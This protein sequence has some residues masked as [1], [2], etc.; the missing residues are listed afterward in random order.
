MEKTKKERGVKTPAFSRRH[1]LRSIQPLSLRKISF[2]CKESLDVFFC[3]H[4][5]TRDNFLPNEC[6]ELSRELTKFPDGINLDG[7]IDSRLFKKC[8]HSRVFDG[9]VI[10]W[11][12]GMRAQDIRIKEV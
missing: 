2:R 10:G 6:A 9:R 11:R 5:I 4:T 12:V 7:V 8:R 1:Q 3:H